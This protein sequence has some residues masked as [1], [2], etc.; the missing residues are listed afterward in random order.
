MQNF[1][2]HTRYHL[3]H[4]HYRKSCSSC[5]LESQ[6]NSLE[7]VL[8]FIGPPESVQLVPIGGADANVAGLTLLLV[9][10]QIK[11]FLRHVCLH[12]RSNVPTSDD[13]DPLDVRALSTVFMVRS[14]L[15]LFYLETDQTVP[16][17]LRLQDVALDFDSQPYSDMAEYLSGCS[18][19]APDCAQ[20]AVWR[21][22][23]AKI[24]LAGWI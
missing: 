1:F 23:R 15:E 19:R 7:C 4:C 20:M 18:R 13:F 9:F 8:F 3:L 14:A 22:M 6:S 12:G 5:D 24:P 2:L 16:S 10:D 21:S 17:P 11:Y